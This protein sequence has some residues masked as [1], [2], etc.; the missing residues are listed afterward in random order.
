M[1]QLLMFENNYLNYE[2]KWERKLL[3]ENA[4]SF[5][6]KT[7]K[8]SRRKRGKLNAESADSFSQKTRKA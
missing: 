7:L 6:Q 5:S 2:I 8:V 4:E 1:L 3:A